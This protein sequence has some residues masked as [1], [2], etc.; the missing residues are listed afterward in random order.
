MISKTKVVGGGEG[1]LRKRSKSKKFVKLEGTGSRGE[2]L[3]WKD[4]SSRR[5][6][7]KGGTKTQGNSEKKRDSGQRGGTKDSAAV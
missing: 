1:R 7:E 3:W 4:Q 5:Y 2:K 6:I